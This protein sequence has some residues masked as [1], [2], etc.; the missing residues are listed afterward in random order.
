MR[1]AAFDVLSA[2]V[3]VG[4][5]RVV[6]AGA[7]VLLLL[8]A[9]VVAPRTAQ[10]VGPLPYD[11]WVWLAGVLDSLGNWWH[12]Q[13]LG[14]QIAI[15]VG[16]A[17]LV[18]LSGGSLAFAFGVSGVLTWGLDKS[19]GLATF[20]RDPEQ[21][22]TDYLITA[23]P[24]QLAGDTLGVALTFGPGAFGGAV[25]GRG[26][27][28]VAT[29]VVADPV[30]WLARQRTIIR[31]TPDAGV[32]DPDWLLGR[33][34]VLL[35][36]GSTQPAL[37]GAEEAAATARYERFD[38]VATKGRPGV[39]QDGQIAV[40]GHN[41]RRIPVGNGKEVH[42]DGYTSTYAALGEYKHVTAEAQTWY[43]P[44]TLDPRLHDVAI[45]KLDRQLLRMQVA[46]DKM[47]EG[48]GVIEVTTNSTSVAAFVESRM[49]VHGLR[50]YVRLVSGGS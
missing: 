42:A 50:G 43:D 36:D 18:A 2:P 48:A 27:R 1:E 28:T 47:A 20:V 8:A 25:L 13:P 24:A 31:E 38:R 17:A 39:A 3:R 21:A 44:S 35:A 14:T 45:A 11:W 15:G 40:Y 29:D 9:L 46:A 16:V 41:E 33:R 7:L 32:I 23:T 12:D 37:S 34:P 5:R 26:V 49:Q 6:A 19:H 10:G 4:V 22:T 30:A